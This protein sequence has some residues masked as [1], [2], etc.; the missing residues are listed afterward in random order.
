[1]GQAADWGDTMNLRSRIRQAIEVGMSV[2]S[3]DV[4]ILSRAAGLSEEDRAALWLYAWHL[5]KDGTA[6]EDARAPHGPGA[7]QGEGRRLGSVVA[8]RRKGELA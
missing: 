3:I 8:L 7:R 2:E 1:M 4:E 6:L 5:S